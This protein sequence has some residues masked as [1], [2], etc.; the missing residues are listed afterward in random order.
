[1]I[2][3]VGSCIAEGRPSVAAAIYCGNYLDSFSEGGRSGTRQG[4]E[5]DD[6]V[7]KGWTESDDGTNPGHNIM[8]VRHG[9]DPDLSIAMEH[10]SQYRLLQGGPYR[11]ESQR[12]W[13]IHH[14][15][16]Y[17]SIMLPNVN[18]M[19]PYIVEVDFPL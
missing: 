13:M 11:Q 7:R 2:S 4:W 19:H 17:P 8:W 12:R 6:K 10:F 5:M 15:E 18:V 9:Q 14:D 16:I 3:A 1:M